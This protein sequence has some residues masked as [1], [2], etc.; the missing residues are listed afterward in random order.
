MFNPTFSLGHG[1][2]E[3]HCITARSQFSFSKLTTL[4]R[5]SQLLI[6]EETITGLPMSAIFSIKGVLL[7]SP[8]GIL[9]AD[10][11]ISSNKSTASKEKEKKEILHYNLRHLP[12]AIHCST[13]NDALKYSKR[14][15]PVK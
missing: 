11:P 14:G 9:Y 6:P 8:D 15:S 4:S 3:E 10:I 2:I 5:S 13:L 12:Y 1:Y 7:I